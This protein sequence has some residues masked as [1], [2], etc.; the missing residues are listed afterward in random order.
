M[1]LLPSPRQ[2]VHKS[3]LVCGSRMS[4]DFYLNLE[5]FEMEGQQP[6]PHKTAIWF[7]LST[8]WW[9]WRVIL[10][11]SLIASTTRLRRNEGNRRRAVLS[12]EE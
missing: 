10:I 12:I 6:E 8:T 11:L 2:I 3:Q 1:K 9:W 5:S 4:L 7:Y